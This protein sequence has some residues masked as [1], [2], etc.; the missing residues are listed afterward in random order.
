M[1]FQILPG[2]GIADA[3]VAPSG[4]SIPMAQA[5]APFG[6]VSSTVADTS[7]RYNSSTG[8]GSG[9]STNWSSWNGGGT[10]SVNTFTLS[11]AQLAAHSHTDSGHAHV[12]SGHQHGA[13]NGG[14]FFCGGTASSF[15]STGGTFSNLTN[16]G[17]ASA[18][19]ETGYANLENTGSGSGITPTYT[20]PSVKYID[21]I[22]AVKS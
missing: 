21:H 18:N 1:P 19:I 17:I 7:L 3:L 13:S 15:G 4:T 12:D 9:G 5:S 20:T 16:T 11:V 8:G 22:L 6:W 10:F 2:Q 14:G